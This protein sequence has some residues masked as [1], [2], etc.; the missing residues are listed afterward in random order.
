MNEDKPGTEMPPE[1]FTAMQQGAA[2]IVEMFHSYRRAGA[3]LV[4][5]AFIVAAQI[6]CGG[7]A[8]G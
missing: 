6:T 3:T 7:K 1:P 2:A 8:D 5:A 4:E